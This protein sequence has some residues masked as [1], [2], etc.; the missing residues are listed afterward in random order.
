MREHEIV[1][2]ALPGS[3]QCQLPLFLVIFNLFI[4]STLFI[5]V[6][7]RSE[8]SGDEICKLIPGDAARE[9]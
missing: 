6:V 5:V 2:S 3:E 1:V 9:I 7:A 8:S 4:H